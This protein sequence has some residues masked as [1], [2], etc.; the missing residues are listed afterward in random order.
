MSQATF[1]LLIKHKSQRA[2]RYY[3]PFTVHVRSHICRILIGCLIE[4]ISDAML[5]DVGSGNSGGGGSSG[6]IEAIGGIGAIP[7]AD[8]MLWATMRRHPWHIKEDNGWEV[9]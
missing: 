6:D 2:P 1:S 8:Q 7:G 5:L 3:H 9:R 4:N